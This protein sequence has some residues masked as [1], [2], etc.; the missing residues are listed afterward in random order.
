MIIGFSLSVMTCENLMRS[1]RFKK[2]FV[3]CNRNLLN[4]VLYGKPT[5]SLVLNFHPFPYFCEWERRGGRKQKY[6]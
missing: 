5:K 2:R 4:I 1:V 3:E 6:L